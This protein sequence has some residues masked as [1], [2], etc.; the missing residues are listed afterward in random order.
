VIDSGERVD[1]TVRILAP[2]GDLLLTIET[3]LSSSER[4]STNMSWRQ[5]I[6]EPYE[7]QS[8]QQRELPVEIRQL[9]MLLRQAEFTDAGTG[10]GYVARDPA[11]SAQI[12]RELAALAERFLQARWSIDGQGRVVTL[13]VSGYLPNYDD[14]DAV[15]PEDRLSE[16]D[17]YDVTG[18]QSTATSDQLRGASAELPP[19]IAERYLS[20]PGS[21]TP[22]TRELAASVAGGEPTVFDTAMAIQDYLRATYPYDEK[23]SGPSGGEDAVDYFLFDEQRGYCE[24]FASAMV[25]MLRSLDVPARLVAGFRDVPFDAD[26]DGY[27]YRQKQAHTWVEVYFPGY[28]WTAFEPTPSEDPFNYDGEEQTDDPLPTPTPEIETPTPEPTIEPTAEST[29]AANGANAAGVD[30]DGDSGRPIWWYLAGGGVVA[31]ASLA[32]G[33]FLFR[34]RAAGVTPGTRFYRQLVRSGQRAGVRP[35][36]STTPRELALRISEAVP[37]AAAPAT[38]MSQLYRKEVYGRQDLTDDERS[39]G[40]MA[41]RLLRKTVAMRRLRRKRGRTGE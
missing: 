14:I 23:I 36:A 19:Y 11:M 4:V 31:L 6:N 25:V 40:E 12:D 2:T 10:P 35:T 3:F 41:G 24:Y 18:W 30:S 27:L 38:T 7:L 21:V 9:A 20:L 34:R 39:M 26:A 5:L 33:L 13:F 29:P 37:P 16:G 17:V 22:A 32:T 28:G 8:L 1:G 15:A